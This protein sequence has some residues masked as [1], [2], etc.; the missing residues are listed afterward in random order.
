M[1]QN[2]SLWSKVHIGFVVL[3]KRTSERSCWDI[4]KGSQGQRPVCRKRDDMTGNGRK[5]L[6]NMKEIRDGKK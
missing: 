6:I 5:L 3:V 1:L 2:K 4:L